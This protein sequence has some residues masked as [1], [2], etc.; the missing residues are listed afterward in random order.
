MGKPSGKAEVSV[1]NI[2]RLRKTHEPGDLPVFA[3]PIFPEEEMG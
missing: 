3:T 2:E 1:P